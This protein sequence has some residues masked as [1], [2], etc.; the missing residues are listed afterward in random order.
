MASLEESLVLLSSVKSTESEIDLT[1]LVETHSP[2]LFRVAHSLLRSRSE[3]EDVVQDTF[4][5]ILERRRRLPEINDM[6]VWL[7]RIAW[8]L[9]LDRIRRRKPQAD[10]AFIQTL[11]APDAPVDKALEETRRMQA[12]L[13]EIERL[14]RAERHALL[15]S[16]LEELTTSEIAT[17]TGRTES[18]VRALIFRART[19]LRTRLEKG[20]Y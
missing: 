15:L 3:A 17:I 8:N 7:V 13:T 18:A 11:V 14:P 6:R 2:L 12:V 19:H 10:A 5:R 16:S 4:L 20:G 9:A 1:A